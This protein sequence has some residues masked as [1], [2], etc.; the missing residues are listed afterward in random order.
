[1]LEAKRVL[2]LKGQSK[3]EVIKELLE[4]VPSWMIEDRQRVFQALLEREKIMATGIGMGV[5]VP[6]VKISGVQEMA[7]AVGIHS[8]GIEWGSLLDTEKARI[9]VLIVAP[10]YKAKEYLQLLAKIVKILKET[11]DKLLR[12]E[13]V[14]EVIDILSQYNV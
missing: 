10:D 5:A 9:V 7:L 8:Q 13:G 4:S 12:A 14:E 11:R 3:E 6:H 1:M 2:F